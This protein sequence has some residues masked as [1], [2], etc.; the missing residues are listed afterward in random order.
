MATIEIGGVKLWYDR[1]GDGPSLVQ[2]HGL[3]LGHANFAYVSPH[4]QQHFQ[5]LDYDMA[6]FG[7]SELP[8]RPYD[9]SD[10]TNE[11][12]ALL[13]ALDIRQTHVHAT[14]SG[15]PIGLQF[16]AEHPERVDRLVVSASFGRYDTMARVASAAKRA[17]VSALGMGDTLA[18]MMALEAFTRPYFDTEDGKAKLEAMKRTFAAQDAAVW[19]HVQRLRENVD[20]T[21]LLPHI[22]APTLFI[23]GAED[24]MTPVDSGPT[25]IGMRQMAEAV[26]NGR[27]ELIEG[28]GHLILA[29]EAEESAR[30]ITRFLLES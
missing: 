5:V 25:G 2:L 29:Q 18:Y 7:D 24:S 9:F 15:G 22:A 14:S 11:L 30:R 8:A 20:V 1:S 13:D 4:L 19:D 28:A 3:A 26:P 10:W 16:A 12:V 27:L 21:P 23:T 6:G 17:V